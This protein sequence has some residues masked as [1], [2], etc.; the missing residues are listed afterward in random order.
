MK[1]SR[2]PDNILFFLK[3]GDFA[4]DNDKLPDNPYNQSHFGGRFRYADTRPAM[5]TIIVAIV[6]RIT[7]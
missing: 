4:M 2:E 1:F 3:K 6:T 7:R 5:M